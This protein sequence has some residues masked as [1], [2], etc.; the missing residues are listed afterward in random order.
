M[1][2]PTSPRFGVFVLPVVDTA[3]PGEAQR[4]LRLAVEDVRLAEELGFDSAWFAEHHGTPY[5]G[6]CPS[7]LMLL[8][9]CA[10]LTSRI[11]LGTAVSVLP[12]HDP[13]RLAEE[14][15]LADHLSEGRLELGVGS[16]FLG[17]DF[18][19]LRVPIASKQER[20]VQALP[21]LSSALRSSP[22][23][24]SPR[25]YPGLFRPEGIPMWGAAALSAQ[26]IAVFAD[27]GMGLM[28]NPYTRSAAEVQHAITLYR[29]RLL[30]AGHPAERARVM[31]HEHLFVAPTEREARERPRAALMHYLG[32]LREASNQS[33]DG[34]ATAHGTGGD[35]YEDL[36]PARVAFGTPD[37]VRDRLCRW[38]EGGVTDFSFSVRF[39]NLAPD[40]ARRSMELFAR[41]V[42]PHLRS[43]SR[44]GTLLAAV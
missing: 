31:I 42:A 30:A 32:T 41:E 23:D 16:G 3:A 29:E 12:L 36:F 26:N 6:S 38:V 13:I 14:A 25:L 40:F 5:G 9:Y 35:H 28:L 20:F 34:N 2:D 44:T 7:A 22:P 1:C 19:T 37:Q 10:G 18:A 11:Q 27:A 21:V 24:T 8:T 17:I 39:G 43:E 33:V 4:A 15:L